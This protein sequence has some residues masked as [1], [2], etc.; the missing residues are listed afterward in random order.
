MAQYFSTPPKDV[1]KGEPVPA[2]GLAWLEAQKGKV[3]E[4]DLALLKLSQ[5]TLYANIMDGPWSPLRGISPSP[6]MYWGVW[7]WDSAFHAMALSRW[8]GAL[9]RE[10]IQIFLDRQ[11]ATG[12]LIDVLW[13]EGDVVDGNGKPPVMPWVM[14]IVH[15]RSPDLDFLKKAYPKFVAYEKHWMEHRGGKADGPFH[16]GGPEPYF[17]AGWDNSV[18]WDPKRE[19]VGNLWPIDLNCY[20]VMVYRSLAEMAE[21]VG[22]TEDVATWRR[23]ER[24]LAERI[25][26]NLWD[27]SN[28]VYVDRNRVTKEFSRV[29][30]PASF[31]PLYVGIAPKPRAEKMA[32]LAADKDGFYP[33][34][35]TVQYRDREF[36]SDA[37]WRGPAWLNVSYMALKGLRKY[38]YTETADAMRKTLL[39]WIAQSP[40][41]LWEYYDSRNGKGLGVRQYGWTAAWTIEFLLNWTEKSEP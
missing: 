29:L 18:R 10:Q 5:E 21:A 31:M 13:R 19:E 11:T 8:D 16:Y 34:M 25:E 14:M 20:M 12:G 6:Y 22:R 26:K 37:Y 15:R 9:A 38:G 1:P 35:P 3:S 30:S 41:T 24:E 23:R 28:G 7:N 2:S 4:R 40:E 17:E 36:K 33:G 39:D 32:V 27:E